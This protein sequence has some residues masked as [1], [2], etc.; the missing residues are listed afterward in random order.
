MVDI[1]SVQSVLEEFFT[2]FNSSPK[3]GPFNSVRIFN[4]A[5]N[6]SKQLI[7][8]HLVDIDVPITFTG[9][10]VHRCDT[11]ISLPGRLCD[12]LRHV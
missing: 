11:D 7:L 2:E 4:F 1:S 8:S 5:S 9:H 3:P 10:N 12:V 6:G